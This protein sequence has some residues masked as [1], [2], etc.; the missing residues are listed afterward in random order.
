MAEGTRGAIKGQQDASHK[1]YEAVQLQLQHHQHSITGITKRLDQLSDMLRSVVETVNE[2]SRSDREVSRDRDQPPRN[3]EERCG[4]QKE[5]R[6]DFP[7]FTGLDPAGWIFKANQYFD[8]FQVPFHQKLMVASHHMEGEAL[9]WYQNALDS[10]QFNSW[11]TL[12]VAMPGKFGPSAFDDLMEALMRLKQTSSVSLYT[13]QFE[14]LSNRLKGLSD[15]HKMSCYISGLKDDIR[16]PVKMCNPMNL[17]AALGLAKLQEEYVLSSRKPWRPN[18]HFAEKWP[19]NQNTLKDFSDE[20]IKNALPWKRVNAS[21]MDEKRRKGLCFHCEEKWNPNHVCKK[22]KVYF[23]QGDVDDLHQ[24]DGEGPLC[25]EN[26]EQDPID[27]DALEVS[28]NAISGSISVNAKRLHGCVGSCAVEILVDSGSTHNFVDLLVV[29]DAKLMA[30]QAS[31]LQVRVANGEKLLSQGSG[32]DVVLGVQWLKTLGSITWNFVDMSM[33]FEWG[34]QMLLPVKQQQVEVCV[35]RPMIDLLEEFSDLMNLLACP[36]EELLTIQSTSR[37]GFLLFQFDPTDELLDE[38]FGARIFSKMDL[39]V[40]YHQIRVREGDIPKTAFRTHEGHYEFLVMPFGLTNAPAT[41]QGLMNHIF[42]PFL[43]RFVLHTLY[44]KMS[45]C[46]FGVQEVEYLGHIII[47]EGVKIDP[48]KTAAMVNWP[49]PK[50]LK[51]L[52]GF[53]GLTGYNK[54]FIRAYGTIAAPL[55]ALLK[56]NSFCWNDKAAV[57]FELLKAVVTNPPVLS[58]PDFTKVFTIECDASV[59]YKK[60]KENLV[61]DALSRK[62]E[63]EQAVVAMISFPTPLWIEELKQSYSYFPDYV[64]LVPKLQQGQQGPKHFSTQQ[65]LLLRK[66]KIV[67]M[68]PFEALYGYGPPKLIS[69]VPGISS[70]HAVDQ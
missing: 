12:V 62:Y 13:T 68:T 50:T 20:G 1:L 36:Q 63:E 28:V 31:T 67:V 60:G 33:Q 25:I 26:G 39:R 14:A 41:F 37:R 3:H 46:K 22:T 21:H 17:G 43:R 49:V 61:V 7:R 6:L 38:L 5:F 32:C 45:K 66:G 11:E 57:A 53:L 70:N 19:V 34:G 64:D 48:A 16:V 24:S 69:Y 35:E 30:H 54:K 40:G 9:V 4:F 15:R 23:I 10:G 47:G 8:C 29:K 56:K 59:D 55:T 27:V 65:G 44:A 42:K 18:P 2:M 51:S 52:R 58:L